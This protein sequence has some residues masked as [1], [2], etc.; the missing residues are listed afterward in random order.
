MERLPGARYASPCGQAVGPVR[1]TTR[2]DSRPLDA[3]AR[4]ASRARPLRSAASRAPRRCGR[5]AASGPGGTR[6]RPD[7]R[8][9]CRTRSRR[10]PRTTAAG[11]GGTNVTLTLVSHT[12]SMWVPIVENA[13]ADVLRLGRERELPA[14]HRR[15]RVDQRLP[16]RRVR[17]LDV[18]D[19]IHRPLRDV[20]APQQHARRPAPLRLDLDA[21]RPRLLAVL[22]VGTRRPARS[23]SSRWVTYPVAVKRSVPPKYCS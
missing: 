22:E 1:A 17:Q 21:A 16:A 14:P 8:R 9:A 18:G 15:R 4:R 6:S 13:M 5:P 11:R 7:A 2:P 23:G 19:R 12:P 20:A 10:G 3:A